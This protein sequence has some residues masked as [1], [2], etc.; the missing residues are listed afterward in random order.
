MIY[1]IQSV[2]SC[3][4]FLLSELTSGVSLVIFYHEFLLHFKGSQIRKFHLY[5]AGF[6]WWFST[7]QTGTQSAKQY[8]PHSLLSQ[9]NSHPAM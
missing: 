5:S 9:I 4:G 6:K 7:Q 1:I 3:L 8:Y 2:F